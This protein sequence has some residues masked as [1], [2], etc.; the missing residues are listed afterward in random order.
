MFVLIFLLEGGRAVCVCVCVCVCLKETEKSRESLR[1]N[2][3]VKVEVMHAAAARI[4]TCVVSLQCF[5]TLHCT[6]KLA[7]TAFHPHES[8]EM[9]QLAHK[10]YTNDRRSVSSDLPRILI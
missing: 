5:L 6:R 1:D 10:L 3:E 9:L 2:Y 4:N 8:R 7:R